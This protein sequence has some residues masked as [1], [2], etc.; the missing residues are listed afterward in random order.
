MKKKDFTVI[1]SWSIVIGLILGVALAISEIDIIVFAMPALIFLVVLIIAAA[2]Y[3]TLKDLKIQKSMLNTGKYDEMI[4]Y[5]I[6]RH[7]KLKGKM[8]YKEQYILNVANCFNRMGKFQESLDYLDRMQVDKMDNNLKAGYCGLYSSDL[9]FL[10][11]DMGKAEELIIKSRNL[12]DMQESMLLHALIS[13]ELNKNETARQL[14]EAYCKKSN[15]K[16]YIL[17]MSTVMYID[18][19]TSKVSEKFMLGLYY[20]KAGDEAKSKMYLTEA[21]SYRYNNY[22]S[23]ISKELNV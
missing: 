13:L 14:V 10:N 8:G 5:S 1:I 22:F 12:I 16:K 3:Y 20:K 2:S 6:G 4:K 11:Q 21:A 9:Y 15:K 7:E 17:G 18:E 23:N 19:Y